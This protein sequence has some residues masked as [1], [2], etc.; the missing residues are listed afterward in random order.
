M[1]DTKPQINKNDRGAQTEI[2]YFPGSLN[3]HAAT[4]GKVGGALE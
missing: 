1:L 4:N 3:T 2:A